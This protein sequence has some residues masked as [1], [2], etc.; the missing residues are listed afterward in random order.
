M[1]KANKLSYK[2]KQQ[3]LLQEISLHFAEGK[4]TGLLGPNG[5]GKSTLLKVLSG[6]WIPT[7]GM[8]LWKEQDLLNRKRIEIS[9]IISLVPQSPSA[10]FNYTVREIVAMGCYAAQK[11]KTAASNE[12]NVVDESL[13]KTDTGHLQHKRIAEISAG[14]RQRVYI[15]RALATDARVLL[16]DEPTANLDIRHQRE[17]WSILQSL[18]AE[19]K[20]I[21]VALHDFPAADRFCDEIA[22]L[23]KGKCTAYGK[24]RDVMT[25]SLIEDV[26]T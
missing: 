21:I 26:F 13:K 12:D 5:A 18:I 10:Y 23:S 14:E 3:M 6:I 24:Y 2:I 17:V 1:L 22:V 4:I 8:V 15:A 19:G 9:Q 7:S 11:N 16:L 25:D 20:T